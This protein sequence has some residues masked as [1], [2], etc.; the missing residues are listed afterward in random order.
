M[1]YGCGKL[2]YSAHM[3]AKCDTLV[4]VDSSIQL[5]RTQSIDGACT[6]VRRYAGKRFPGCELHELE[7]FWE[8]DGK[9]IDL[10]LCANV[11]SAIPNVRVRS[12]SLNA[13][14][15]SLSN[16]GKLL[17]VNQYADRYFVEAMESDVN[18]YYL[19]GWLGSRSYYGLLDCGKVESLLTRHGFDV[20]SSWSDGK[21]SFVEAT[22][23]R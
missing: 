13:L 21:S 11:L 14:C 4:L 10:V 5:R 19:D 16:R 17:V 9:Q 20:L 22:C 3:F 7:A 12:R 1:D 2:R 15:A 6:S 8:G 18:E 23:G